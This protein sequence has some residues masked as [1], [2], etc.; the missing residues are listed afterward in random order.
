MKVDKDVER[1][2][3]QSTLLDT[4]WLQYGWIF[5]FIS[6][7]I[8]DQKTYDF[9]EDTQER[10]YLLHTHKGLQHTVSILSS[11]VECCWHYSV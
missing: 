3:T 7:K 5:L 8:F 6:Y 11:L 10:D 4:R 2:L 1:F 9:L